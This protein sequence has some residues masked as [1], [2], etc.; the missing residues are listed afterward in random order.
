M[1]VTKTDN[2]NHVLNFIN[3]IGSGKKKKKYNFF[4]KKI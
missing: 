1:Y 2:F 4:T 3:K